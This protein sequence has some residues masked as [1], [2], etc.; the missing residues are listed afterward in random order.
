MAADVKRQQEKQAIREILHEQIQM[1]A[2]KKKI[3]KEDI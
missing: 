3:E 2:L 1:D